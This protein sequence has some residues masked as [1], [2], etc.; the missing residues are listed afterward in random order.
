M[1][2]VDISLNGRSYPVACDSGQEPRLRQ[3][4]SYVDGVTRDMAGRAP[5]A[6]EAQLLV[7]TS[8]QLADEIADLRL[9]L[10]AFTRA[11]KAPAREEEEVVA[12]VDQ[13]A[14]KIEDIAARLE[15]A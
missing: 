12:A 11:Q 5:A 4:A 6:S 1:P 9:Q 8:L 13:L 2:R 14:K 15:R 10:A 3:L 7:L